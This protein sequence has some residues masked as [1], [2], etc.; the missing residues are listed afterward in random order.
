MHIS[1]PKIKHNA[2]FPNTL[3]PPK[4]SSAI[5][6]IAPRHL[7]NNF[8]NLFLLLLDNSRA[9][10]D[11]IGLNTYVAITCTTVAGIETEEYIPKIL[12]P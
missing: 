12:L 10:N 2:H 6:V 1:L 9:N 8:E 4:L 3:A 11:I 5:I 7:N